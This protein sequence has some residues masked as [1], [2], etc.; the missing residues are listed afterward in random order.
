MDLADKEKGY[1]EISWIL[2]KVGRLRPA[3]SVTMQQAL[4]VH[5]AQNKTFAQYTTRK[6]QSLSANKILR[7]TWSA[8]EFLAIRAEQGRGGGRKGVVKRSMDS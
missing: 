4:T 8:K 2:G 5:W 6:P 7:F 3:A 1:H